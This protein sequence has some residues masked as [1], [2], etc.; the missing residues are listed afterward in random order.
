L[1]THRPN[2][3]SH[4]ITELGSGFKVASDVPLVVTGLT[5]RSDGQV[6]NA[7]MLG[8]FLESVVDFVIITFVIFLIIKALLK[9]A[10]VAP[11]PPT[12]ACGQCPE[13]VAAEARKCKLC[14]SD[15]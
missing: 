10:P 12:K 14:C 13:T 3:N 2:L 9:P 1:H 4:S 8:S 15:F 7:I 6:A 5:P 11:P